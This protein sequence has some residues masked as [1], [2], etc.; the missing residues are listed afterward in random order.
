MA[1]Y[2]I[3]LGNQIGLMREF[4]SKMGIPNIRLKPT[5]NPYTEPSVEVYGYHDGLAKWVELANCGV[6]RP[7]MTRPMGIPEGVQILGWGLSLERPTMIKYGIS[8]IR[9][10]V[11]PRV[12]LHMVQQNPLCRLDKKNGSNTEKAGKTLLCKW[13]EHVNKLSELSRSTQHQ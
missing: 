11:G 2:G 5:Y 4:F 6:F 3:T 7:E 13:D 1:E 9:E 10:L 12:N 8:N